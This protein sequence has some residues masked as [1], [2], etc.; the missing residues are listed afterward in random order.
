MKH[1][2]IH[3]S[4]MKNI[5]FTAGVTLLLLFLLTYPREALAA[6]RDGM[7]LWLNTLFPT[8][9]PFLVLT[10]ILTHTGLIE[11]FL[12]P[13]APFFR[14]CFG[15][16]PSGAYAFLLGL[17]CGYPMGAKIASELYQAGKINRREAE[18]LLTFANNPS[19]AFLTNYLTVDCL[20]GRTPVQVTILILLLSDMICMV[21]FRL[22]VFR[23][24]TYSD[25]SRLCVDRKKET[26]CASS[27]GAVIDVSIMN[28]FE[29]IARLGGYILLFSLLAAWLH[30][31]WPFASTG[32]YLILGIT[33]LTTGLHQLD[34]AGLSYPLHYL[35]AMIMTAFGGFCIMAQTKSVLDRKL[36]LRPYA[37][38]KCLNAAIT[39]IL[40]LVFVKF[41]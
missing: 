39:A 9:L 6:A 17:L 18:Y 5:L 30:H 22:A 1:P 27:P 4:I 38:A 41:I 23:N 11:H 10:G 40:V 8:L 2:S 26:I 36:S 15:L 31:Y 35:C 16:S 14:V 25:C 13:L 7:D 32:K 20:N 3:Q 12:A 33:E 19:P 34:N 29:T 37:S 28:G 24:Q 21:F